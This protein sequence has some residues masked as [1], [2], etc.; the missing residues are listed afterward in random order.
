MD[1]RGRVPVL[2]GAA[3]RRV[4]SSA[5]PPLSSLLPSVAVAVKDTERKINFPSPTNTSVS[6]QSLFSRGC[7]LHVSLLLSLPVPSPPS[8]T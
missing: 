6:Y 4:L 5:L 2:A 3:Y 7:L 1:Q 8:L